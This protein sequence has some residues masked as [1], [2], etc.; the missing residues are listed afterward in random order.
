MLA[1]GIVL[2]PGFQ[3]MDLASLTP[4]EFANLDLGHDFYD[5]TFLSEE[6]GPIRSSIGMVIETEPFADRRF[7]TIIVVGAILISPSAPGLVE[8]LRETAATA[9]RVAATCTGAFLLAAAGLLEGRRAATHWAH[10]RDLQRLHS[11][12]KVD[13]DRIFVSDGNVWTSAGMTAGIDLA[14]ALVEDDLGPEIS[15]G[16][17]QKTRRLSPKDGRPVAVLRVVGASAA[18]RPGPEGPGL[19]EGQ[20]EERTQRRGTRGSRPPQPAPVQPRLPGG[21]RQITREGRRAS[22]PGR[23]PDDAGRRAAFARHRGPGDRLC[24]PGEDEARLSPGVRPTA[25]GHQAECASPR[26]FP[27]GVTSISSAIA[28]ARRR[29]PGSGRSSN[30]PRS[31]ASGSLTNSGVGAM[32]RRVDDDTRSAG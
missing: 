16:H 5:V 15:Q 18:V 30:S 7:D 11:S 17:R 21:D 1:I 20:S 24:G 29:P 28:S 32:G 23:R 2:F 27:D 26:G 22:T 10:A 13:D 19:C 6:G 8:R 9:R 4:F 25:P 31:Q 12:I 3:V 14:L